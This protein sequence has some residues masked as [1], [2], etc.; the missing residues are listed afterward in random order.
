VR[1]AEKVANVTG[2]ATGNGKAIALGF[3]KQGANV[4]IIDV[5]E[6]GARAT[7]DEIDSSGGNSFSIPGDVSNPEDVAEAVGGILRRFGRI[8]I[9][10]NNA[11]IIKKAP[12]LEFSLED[13]H[14]VLMVNLTGPFLCSQR[15]AE[16]MRKQ[17]IRGSI[18]NITSISGEMARPNTA[19]YAASKG[20]LK[21]LTK[22]MAV[23]LAK[24]K[25]R[26]NAIAP[27]YVRTSS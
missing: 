25:I 4:A 19:A 27:S 6:N 3:A 14:R 5:D 21:G 7:A 12:F 8:D 16:A 2:A 23:D 17:G 18:I 24:F 11:G 10:V 26:V 22:A 1:L 15:V 9:L 13:W 20:G